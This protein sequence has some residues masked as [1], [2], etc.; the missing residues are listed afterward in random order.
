MA[1]INIQAPTLGFGAT[2]GIIKCQV[3]IVENGTQTGQRIYYFNPADF[4]AYA[5]QINLNYAS[6]HFGAHELNLSNGNYTAF[7]YGGS[8]VASAYDLVT[9]VADYIADNL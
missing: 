2:S 9:T 8:P 5:D 7:A 6:L 3:D 4:S 1:T